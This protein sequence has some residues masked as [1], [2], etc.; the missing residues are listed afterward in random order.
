MHKRILITG[1]TSGI[2]L[3]AARALAAGGADV[4]I[5]GR[6]RARTEGAAASIA[7]AGKGVAVDTFLADLSSLASVRRLAA[8]VLGRYA[9]LDVLI[10]NAGAMYQVRQLNAEGIEMTWALNHLA[11]FLLTRLLLDRLRASTPAR[12]ITTA[13]AAHQEA[14]IPFDDLQADRS[15]GGFSRY[16]QTKLANILFTRELARRLE[17]SGVTANAFHPGLV[18]TNFNRNN[19]PLMGLAMGLLRA[20]SLSPEQGARTL[21]WLAESP[22]VAEVSGAYFVA[23]RQEAPSAAARDRAV[24]E[25]LWSVSE[26]QCRLQGMA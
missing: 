4:A 23:E 19:G 9:R 17:G 7:A 25:R 16:G 2:G 3:A 24:G 26:K 22:E 13:S 5:V 18:A 12:I 21:V 20:F 8:D 10:N 11:P 15:Y 14:H 6:S 1:A